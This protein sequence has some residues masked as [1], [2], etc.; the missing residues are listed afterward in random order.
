MTPGSWRAASACGT[1]LWW[2]CRPRRGPNDAQP[3]KPTKDLRPSFCIAI[4]A[5]IASLGSVT[6][7]CNYNRNFS[8]MTAQSLPYSVLRSSTQLSF[9]CLHTTLRTTQKQSRNNHSDV[10]SLSPISLSLSATTVSAH[11]TKPSA[12]SHH[13]TSTKIIHST[14]HAYQICQLTNGRCGSVASR[15]NT[16]GWGALMGSCS[17]FG[18]VSGDWGYRERERES[19]AVIV[20]RLSCGSCLEWC[21]GRGRRA[22]WR[23]G[24]LNRGRIALSCGCP[25]IPVNLNVVWVREQLHSYLNNINVIIITSLCH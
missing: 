18:A 24:G 7:A 11:S 21:A 22:V 19:V 4:P 2:P 9:L 5:L 16:L 14:S 8:H 6:N 12:A 23:N 3:T 17:W 25:H 20:T 15:M 13:G 10:L 1:W